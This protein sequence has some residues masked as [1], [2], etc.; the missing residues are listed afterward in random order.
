MRNTGKKISKSE[1]A[2]LEIEIQTISD[3]NSGLKAKLAKVTEELQSKTTQL[4]Q[5]DNVYEE[6]RVK[7]QQIASLHE[8]LRS[9][10]KKYEQLNEKYIAKMDSVEELANLKIINTKL[11]N[12]NQLLAKEIETLKNNQPKYNEHDITEL[13]LEALKIA[14]ETRQAALEEARRIHD[15]AQ[16]QIDQMMIDATNRRDNLLSLAEEQSSDMLEKA[17]QEVIDTL[18]TISVKRQVLRTQVD[19]YYSRMKQFNEQTQF[20]FEEFFEE[21]PQ[22]EIDSLLTEE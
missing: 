9:S 20:I 4:N 17:H 19:N 21:H 3:E 6:V 22:A 8:D 16:A 14:E 7:D 18:A 12:D 2:E 1:L 13:R 10:S 15:E 5:F 11:E